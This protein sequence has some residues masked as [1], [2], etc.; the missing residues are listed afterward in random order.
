MKIFA[1]KV[2][3]AK[4]H[5]TIAVFLFEDSKDLPDELNYIKDA[6]DLKYYS[7]KDGEVLF[8]PFSDNPNILICG[9][10]K[11]SEISTD[12]IRNNAASITKVCIEKK[13][14]DVHVVLPNISLIEDDTSCKTIIEGIYLANYQFIKYKN[15]EKADEPVFIEKLYI[16]SP[17]LALQDIIKETSIIC[18]NTL[19]CRDLVNETSDFCTPEG[20]ATIAKNV[21]KIRGVT[22]KILLKEEITKLKMGLL[23]AVNRGSDVE[24][25]C[26]ILKYR[27]NP[28]SKKYFALVGKGI[29]FDSGGMNLKPTGSMETMRMDMAGAATV[30]YTLKTA[31][32]LKLK[33]NLYAVMPLT[34]NMLSNN[35]F[36]PGD[37]FTAYNGKTVEIGNTDAEGRLILADAL[38]YTEEKLKPEIIVDLATLTGACVVTFGELIAGYLSN[39]DTLATLLEKASARTGDK[40][41]R[42]PLYSEYQEDIKS[43]IADLNNINPDKKA[44]TI[45]GGTFLKN[46]VDHTS[47]AHIDIAGTAWLSKPKGFMPKNGTG[48]GVRLLI[49]AISNWED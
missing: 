24:P 4:F 45:I 28:K 20:F 19:E 18:K 1:Q 14:K 37:I 13:L 41:W 34:D 43:D 11:E 17:T 44:G 35:A 3:Q 38:S 7:A 25:K 46:F 12:K 29:T 2:L 49:E 10:G 32:E 16:Y 6:L 33:K 36:R 31:A 9:L 42:L 21:G 5:E 26:I 15:F 39:D 47:W 48:F 23:L 22:C 40:I 8:V 30:L 27:G